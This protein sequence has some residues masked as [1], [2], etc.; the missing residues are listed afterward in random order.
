VHPE[1]REAALWRTFLERRTNDS[2]QLLFDHYRPFAVRLARA[3]FRRR[4]RA[5]FEL[6]DLEQLA[7]EA[8]LQAIDRFAPSKGA[9]FES[10]ARLR[11]RGQISSGLAKMS[12]S[13]AHANYR[14]RA[15]RD[16]LRSLSMDSAQNDTGDDP[17]QALSRLAATLVLGIML[18]EGA[19]NPDAIADAAPSAYESLALREMQHSL[20]QQVDT[21]PER[22]TFVLRQ[23]YA[24]DVSFTVIAELLGISK[25]RVSQ[26]HRQAL[27]RLRS[28]LAKFR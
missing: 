6:G 17:L 14:R 22:E 24:K 12:E 19:Q 10:F 2:R 20:W 28:Q 23:H 4:Q 13:G 8:L 15:E 26:I 5:N 11:I 1:R 9:P 25:G 18:D 7:F 16:R 3:E 21:L 27:L